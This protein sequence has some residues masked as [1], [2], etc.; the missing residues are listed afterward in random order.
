MKTYLSFW[1]VVVS[2]TIVIGVISYSQESLAPSSSDHFSFNAER[3]FWED[4][5]EKS[6]GMNLYPAMVQRYSAISENEA[7]QYAH[8]FGEVLYKNEGIQ[9]FGVCK[10]VYIW[11]CS[12]S[13]VES[14]IIYNGLPIIEQLRSV[15][16]DMLPGDAEQCVH[17]IG[18]G[19]LSHLGPENLTKALEVCDSIQDIMYSCTSGVIMEFLGGNIHNNIP[20]YP[21]NNEEKYWQCPDLPDRYKAVCYR[22]LPSWWGSVP[23]LGQV[24]RMNLL[25]KN[26]MSVPEPRYRDACFLGVGY[27]VVWEEKPDTDV[28]RS[29]CESLGDPRV[30]SV[31]SYGAALALFQDAALRSAA[32]QLCPDGISI[33]ACIDFTARVLRGQT[34]VSLPD[35]QQ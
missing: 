30:R 33:E 2:V 32:P 22:R 10:N 21:Y 24:E 23:D 15:C 20:P 12:H 31:C 5:F 35:I 11:G 3:S 27:Q 19:I 9:S 8:I 13:F 4:Q 1:S 26:C 7:H 34:S 14:A 28:I 29:M 17:G 18:H 25:E 6:S 16:R